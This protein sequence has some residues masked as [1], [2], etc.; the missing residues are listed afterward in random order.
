MLNL[1]TQE[2]VKQPRA[3]SLIP[4]AKKD[5][6]D[7]ILSATHPDIEKLG[8]TVT[9]SGQWMDYVTE[10]ELQ[11]NN[12]FDQYTC[13]THTGWNGTQ[14]LAKCKYGA[15][16]DKSK[17]YTAVKSNTI[18]RRGNS[19]TNVVESIRNH[20][21]VD[22]I[23]YPTTVENMTE[24]EFYK[25][26]TPEL[27]QKENFRP[28]WLF[29]HA[30][31][32]GN[33]PEMI[34]AALRVSPIMVSVCGSYNFDQN[35]YIA[36]DRSGMITHEVLIVGYELNKYWI[37]LDSENQNGFVRF[38]WDYIF[39]APKALYLTKKNFMQIYRIKGRSAMY[40]L[41]PEGKVVIPFT[42]GVIAGGSLFKIFFGD[43][44]NVSANL[45]VVEKEELLPYPIAPYSFTTI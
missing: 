32:E 44:K 43:Y 15:T 35:G 30:W 8:M 14:C 9:P 12:I 19:V 29:N 16:L 4:E 18:P 45:Q 22:E 27:D 6:R 2:Q 37:V 33:S 28:F 24:T 11:R 1:L 10:F 34:M 39:T 26:I 20:G 5:P 23:D 17:R 42:D 36:Q 21:G 7:Y 13:V 41:N 40:F 38:A 3:A 25:K 31:V